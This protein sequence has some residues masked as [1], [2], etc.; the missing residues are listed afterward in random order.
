MW[1]YTVTDESGK[2]YILTFDREPTQAEIEA[3]IESEIWSSGKGAIMQGLE[4]IPAFGI[5]L[6]KGTVS[7]G[8]D[9]YSLLG[10]TGKTLGLDAAGQWFDEGADAAA[11]WERGMDKYVRETMPD[12]RGTYG[13]GSMTAQ[14]LPM[15]VPAWGAS[16][17]APAVKWLA[18]AATA[19]AAGTQSSAGY[20]RQARGFHEAQMAED[21]F[22]EKYPDVTEE[23]IEMMAI[24]R[25]APWAILSGVKTAALTALGGHLGSKI[26]I[27]GQSIGAGP[28]AIAT[29]TSRGAQHFGQTGLQGL[30]RASAI[31]GVEA[32]E[33]TIDEAVQIAI[34]KYTINESM[35][36]GD[37]KERLLTAA[38]A[39][40][41]FGAAMH[42]AA[43][44]DWKVAQEEL[45]ISQKEADEAWSEKSKAD[46]LS[47]V[48]N[49]LGK[50]LARR[51]SQ[52][53]EIEQGTAARARAEFFQGSDSPL[54][55]EQKSALAKS[56]RGELLHTEEAAAA[57][58]ALQIIESTAMESELGMPLT[59]TE[60]QAA[61]RMDRSADQIRK[62]QAIQ[63]LKATLETAPPESVDAINEKIAQISLSAEPVP[64]AAVQKLLGEMGVTSVKEAYDMIVAGE[65]PAP[66]KFVEEAVANLEAEQD[67]QQAAVTEMEEAAAKQQLELEDSSSLDARRREKLLAPKVSRE[68]QKEEG[69]PTSTNSILGMRKAERAGR[70]D[71]SPEFTGPKAVADAG[72]S[73]GRPDVPSAEADLSFL[74]GPESK[75]ERELLK[76]GEEG[77]LKRGE[78]WSLKRL[79]KKLEKIRKSRRGRMN[80]SL[81]A[82]ADQAVITA[83]LEAAIVATNA[84]MKVD[85]ALESAVKAMEDAGFHISKVN[86]NDAKREMAGKLSD[87]ISHI[88]LEEI[89]ALQTGKT[90]KATKAKLKK[91]RDSLR[92]YRKS[93]R[94][95]MAGLDIGGAA[96]LDAAFTVTLKA[97]EAGDSLATA[98][99]KGYDTLGSTEVPKA[100]FENYMGKRM[101]FAV[102]ELD[103]GVSLEDAVKS[104]GVPFDGK[105]TVEMMDT[106]AEVEEG[107][108]NGIPP[109]TTKIANLDG[110][111]KRSIGA[112]WGKGTADVMSEGENSLAFMSLGTRIKDHVDKSDEYVGRLQAMLLDSGTGYIEAG[113]WLSKVRG[114]E[115]PVQKRASDEWE[116]YQRKLFRTK[117]RPDISH[118]SELGQTL[119]KGWRK[120]A[121]YTGDE[122]VDADLK[123][124]G[125][126]LLDGK[127]N[128][129]K[130][131]F[132][133]LGEDFWM[134]GYAPKYAKP[135][136]ELQ[137]GKKLEGHRDAE[138]L[139]AIGDIL[140]KHKEIKSVTADNIFNW[141]NRD[142]LTKSSLDFTGYAEQDAFFDFLGRGREKGDPI[143]ELMD[144]SFEAAKRYIYSWSERM[145][146]IHAYGQ[147]LKD[148]KDLFQIAIDK[149]SRENNN[150]AKR[151]VEKAR[152]SAYQQLETDD[153]SI[154]LAVANKAAT[155][156]MLTGGFNAIRNL[157]GAGVTTSVY[158]VQNSLKA[159]AEMREYAEAAK[160]SR[161]WGVLRDD[162][163]LLLSGQDA[164]GESKLDMWTR[165][166]LEGT[167]FTPAENFV[168]IHAAMTAKIFAAEGVGAV[169]K[170]KTRL[171]TE[172]KRM[173]E[174]MD[175]DWE[176]MVKEDNPEG[177]VTQRFIRRAVKE[178]QGGYRFDQL[179]AFM[180]TPIGKLLFKFGAYSFQVSRAVK[181]NVLEERSKGNY[182]PLLR[183][184]AIAGQGSGELLYEL[185]RL[186]YGKEKP[187]ATFAEIRKA[188]LPKSFKE[189]INHPAIDRM[190][191]NMAYAGTLG[192]IGD[193]AGTTRAIQMQQRVKNP[194]DP[195]GLETPNQLFR[196]ITKPL[197]TKEPWT[198]EDNKELVHNISAFWR[199]NSALI[200]EQSANVG[201][202]WDAA[203]LQ[204]ARDDR[205]ALRGATRRFQLSVGDDVKN[206]TSR[207]D[208][209]EGEFTAELRD[210]KN[211]LMIGDVFAA[212]K[213]AVVFAQDLPLEKRE[214]A[215][216]RISNSIQASQPMKIGDSYRREIKDEFIEWAR[217]N[218]DDEQFMQVTSVQ[219]R[220]MGAAANAGLIGAAE[221][222]IE[223]EMKIILNLKA[224]ASRGGRSSGRTISREELLD[225]RIRN[226]GGRG[227]SRDKGVT[228]EELLRRQ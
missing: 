167:G 73:V 7:A 64:D 224:P 56:E 223:R 22:R 194:L 108:K 208:Y 112:F 99:Q 85:A 120:V 117:E 131:D 149:F 153:F 160:T 26:K 75:A 193:L 129:T 187:H 111:F 181:R 101:L 8:A 92:K 151:L 62:V 41:V 87:R 158:G 95:S 121:A 68:F 146:Q 176:S 209:K 126:G 9:A 134:R 67:G 91:I 200:L 3:R 168:R 90:F 32:T 144:F 123:V 188:G 135:L 47:K 130:R 171:A 140:L 18:P 163:S 13:A 217:R 25:A 51:L 84:G 53:Y 71:T 31:G 205:N 77:E 19:A 6:A 57:R 34:D 79:K 37:V 38:G 180:S 175:V 103:K 226:S 28:E 76:R 54:T 82:G 80:V 166:G 93:G 42:G 204:R 184:L 142:R 55:Q 63:N 161:S 118:Y 94:V 207:T 105:T 11:G 98:M 119:I 102:D 20:L 106:L 44:Y 17:I 206:L 183:L 21:G 50:N 72:P 96:V 23:D 203:D 222:S 81:L 182:W 178:V 213:A 88:E 12:A 177:V 195:A 116:D 210:I 192:F 113:S 191:N 199:Y 1:S 216:S 137:K 114:K 2:E 220:Y 186:I 74:T 100:R 215:W 198:Y 16:K 221:D 155:L 139:Q 14:V 201:I 66:I 228:R 86:H 138:V 202:K 36:W 124:T 39:G 136:R 227:Q 104:S 27:G 35:G 170:G 110:W 97:M 128:K 190:V 89:A 141:Y 61:S 15:I 197:Y 58:E 174:R 115:T 48:E 5:G 4:K 225:N 219:D 24:G 159:F 143:E 78:H 157:T 173:A 152:K 109:P 59:V 10:A 49:S 169:N 212:R 46:L 165:G 145:A 60:Q 148:G 179:P 127:Q 30:G 185:R 150:V 65:T 164:G 147:E 43:R 69:L 211:A 154:G 33:E 45:N 107:K 70:P 83:G 125:E 132:K 122:M 196:Y 172:F 218:L 162:I 133:R 40:F 29:Q 214:K 52:Q 156:L 189:L